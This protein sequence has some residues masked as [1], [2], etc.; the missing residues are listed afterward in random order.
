MQ[1]LCVHTD[2]R[3]RRHAGYLSLGAGT[4]VQGGGRIGGARA[5]LVGTVV[6]DRYRIDRLLG[7]GGMGAVY[8]AEH[9]HMR[10]TVAIKILHRPMVAVEEAV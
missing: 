9:V 3:V 6:A 8:R 2:Q 7:E 10:R 5:S 1:R 4:S